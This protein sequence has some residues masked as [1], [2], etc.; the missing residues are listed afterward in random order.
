MQPP[1]YTKFLV[2]GLF[3]AGSTTWAEDAAG[4]AAPA[5]D[6]TSD[7]A[8]LQARVEALEA[9]VR[10][11]ERAL[12]RPVANGQSGESAPKRSPSPSAD[13]L[14]IG[15]YG[16]VKYGAVQNPDANG[17]WQNGFDGGRFTLQPAY[18]FS[19]R[20]VLK[21]EIEFEHGGIALDDDD[22]LGGSAEIEQAYLDFTVNEHLHWRAP[23]ID[24]VP[25]GYTNLY[26]EPTLFYSVDRP[27]LAQG[28]VPT[29]W[30]EGSTSIH[31][32]LAGPVSYQIQ[33]STSIVDDGGNTRNAT[34]AGTPPAGGYPAGIDGHS[35]FGLSRATVGDFHQ[36]SDQLGYALRL[37][38]SIP[39]IPGLQGSSSAYWTPNVEPRG[40]YATDALG[41]PLGSLGRCAVTLVDTELRYRPNHDG[42]EL[43]GEAVGAHF[44]RPS[45]LRA[46]NDG[47]DTDNVGRTMWGV[48]G[49]AAYHCACPLTAWELVPFY[50]YTVQDLQM[51]GVAGRDAN[52][53][54]GT[55]RQQFHT[56]GVAAFPTPQIVLKVDCRIARDGSSSTPK[57]DHVLGGVGF[58]F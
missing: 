34:D 48:S 1:T 8:A 58:F 38:Y 12:E 15:A 9:H 36:E 47:D 54:D 55:G 5:G 35:A 53:P 56:F 28:L 50:R 19:D 32:E 20:I 27:E 25:F 49:E 30:F 13:A 7:A 17:A 51:P 24:L 40:A 45:E 42:I 10:N 11:L 2:L 44:S 43:R 37:A 23:G 3:A 14:S 26:H 29:T 4:T 16:E 18:Q 39:A 22:K 6:G 21:A 52:A 33:V 31:G 41:T 46:N 57:D